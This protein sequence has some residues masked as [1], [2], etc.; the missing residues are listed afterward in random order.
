M[1]RLRIGLNGFGRIGRSFT[2]ISLE[3]NMFDI[4]L[5][6]TRKTPTDMLSYLLK[7]DSVYGRFKKEVSSE[8]DTLI[9]GDKKIKTNLSDSIENIPWDVENVDVVVDATGAFKKSEE[10]KKHIK[11]SVKK[12]I[13]T[14]P[15]KD[16]ETPHIV[17]GVNDKNFDFASSSIISNCSCTTNCAAIMFKVLDDAFK[18]QSGFL[19][20]IHSYTP[21]QALLDDAGKDYSRSRAAAINIVPSTTGASDAVGKVL[22]QLIGKIEGMSLRVPV[23]SV[24]FTDISCLV[25]KETS[26]DEINNMFKKE[27][28]TNLKSFLGFES[29]YLVSSDFIGSEFSCIF[30]SNHTKT[31]NKKLVKISGWYDNEWGYSSRL[32]DLVNKLGEFI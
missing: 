21:T 20:T 17:L 16:Q 3:K 30:D 13:L 31:V 11:E 4:V 19:T 24:S 9:I 25:E 12:V 5:I 1:K 6:N 22:P 18:I 2:R 7:H 14:A 23:S 29:D 10:L 28:E 32:V 27:S 26:S 8:K 15:S